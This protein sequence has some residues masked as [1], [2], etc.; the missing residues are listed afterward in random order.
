MLQRNRRRVRIYRLYSGWNRRRASRPRRSLGRPDGRKENWDR[1][2]RMHQR[3]AS[4]RLWREL[5]ILLSVI[6]ELIRVNTHLT[7]WVP[8]RPRPSINCS[9]VVARGER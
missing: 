7:V 9:E 4:D 3:G 5:G 8:A 1:H 6:R 2:E